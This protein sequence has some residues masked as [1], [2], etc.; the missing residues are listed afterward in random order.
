MRF[1]AT[2]PGPRIDRPALKREID[3]PQVV[4]SYLGP[5]PGRRGD[6]GRRLW[7]N[8]PFHKDANPSFC[9]DPERG[10][11]KCFGCGEHGD[12]AGLV[13]KMEGVP[14]P[15]AVRRLAGGSITTRNA[16]TRSATTPTTKP[17][18]QPT[19]LPEGE[20]L[21]LVE[22]SEALLWSPQGVEALNDL[23][24]SRFLGDNAIKSARLGWTDG[25]RIPTKNGDRPF[26]AQGIVIPWFRAG[27]LALLKIR[28]PQDRKPRYAEAFRDPS[29]MASY[30]APETIASGRPLVIVEGEFDS[31]LLGQELADLASV[32][33]LGGASNRPDPNLRGRCLVASSLWLATDNDEAGDRAAK[34]WPS[35]TRR[36]RPP[37]GKDWTEAR[38]RGVDLR[39]WWTDVF[40]G[41]DKPPLFTWEE[42]SRQRWGG[43]DETPGI[44]APGRPPSLEALALIVNP[45][46][47]PEALAEREAIQAENP[48]R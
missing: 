37:A 22:A 20:A 41:V 16:P 1:N 15:E 32:L 45:E 47:D 6:R 29:R 44:D 31:L 46:G 42:L 39:R 11:W 27:R 3:L 4:T 13:M 30:P 24:T 43:A 48:G 35:Q 21:A 2:A 38:L 23:R 33:T 17:P 14:F 9:V 26:Q 28:Q 25:V 34:G 19:G 5:P 36:V 40:R 18:T 10:S 7:W 8:C 12:A